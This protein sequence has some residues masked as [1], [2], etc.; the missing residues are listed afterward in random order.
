M[1]N[2]LKMKFSANFVKKSICVIDL[3]FLILVFC[4]V[5]SLFFTQMYD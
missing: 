1:E 5:F 2:S 3:H 4:L